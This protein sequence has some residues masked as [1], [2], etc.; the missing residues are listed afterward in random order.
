[1]MNY[2]KIVILAVLAIILISLFFLTKS[3]QSARNTAFWKDEEFA[4]ASIANDGVTVLDLFLH[5]AV[6]QAS[7]APL[8]YIF[9]KILYKIKA[10]LGWMEISD[11]VYYRL[12]SI[13]STVIMGFF[14]ALMVL[15]AVMRNSL[16]NKGLI[17]YLQIAAILLGVVSF[18]FWPT[19]RSFV[20]Q[21]RPYSL[22][23]ALWLSLLT[24]ILINGRF[25]KTSI[26]IMVL[27]AMSATGSL[28]QLLSL[29]LGFL[30]AKRFSRIPGKWEILYCVKNLIIP[31]AIVAF[32]TIGKSLRWEYG[33][34]SGYL[35]DFF[36]FWLSK[37]KIPILSLLG[38]VLAWRKEKF[39]SQA[40][41]FLTML[42]L[43]L[44]APVINLIVLSRGIFFTSRYYIYFDLIYPICFFGLALGLPDI[45]N[46]LLRKKS[47]YLERAR[48]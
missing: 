11:L 46:F 21:M 42:I 45:I 14:A 36:V 47:A 22:W 6:E 10:P 24:G 4:L 25:T 16:N 26:L 20:V 5:G 35:H 38:I 8:D 1:M 34:F 12:S 3:V 7:P 31:I 27:L 9:L 44:I 30:I 18:L 19:T 43:Y 2:K 28:F 23:N 37:E 39:I 41:V 32:Y 33:N 29:G 48:S 40:I 15:R 17:L 13:L